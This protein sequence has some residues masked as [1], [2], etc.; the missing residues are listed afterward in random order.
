MKIHNRLKR[1]IN[2]IRARVRYAENSE[3]INY[4]DLSRLIS[5]HSK[6]NARYSAYYPVAITQMFRDRQR[7]IFHNISL[8][9]F[10]YILFP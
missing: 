1:N 7:K 9:F 3:M 5:I 10:R 4:C 8:Y 2:S 6:I